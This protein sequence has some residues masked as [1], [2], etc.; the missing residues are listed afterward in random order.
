MKQ[1]IMAY[2]QGYTELRTELEY[3]GNK[4]FAHYSSFSVGD[5]SSNYKLQTTNYKLA[6]SGYSGTAGDSLS[7]HNGMAFTTNDKDSDVE[8][9]Y[10]CGE[11]FAGAWW[12]KDCFE[13]S[14]NG[15]WGKDSGDAMIWKEFNSGKIVSVSEIKIGHVQ[16]KIIAKYTGS[17]KETMLYKTTHI[18]RS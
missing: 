2:L 11:H 4:A 8:A 10:N 9:Y 18:C 3:Q 6:V 13:P 1:V 5:Q 14:L 7:Y 17:P 16:L 15:V 12:Y